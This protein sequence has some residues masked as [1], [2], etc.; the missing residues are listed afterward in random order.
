MREVTDLALGQPHVIPGVGLEEIDAR[1][2]HVVPGRPH[3]KARRH[4][5]MARSHNQS[6]LRTDGES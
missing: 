6:N 5:R 4:N 3:A 1:A 2:E